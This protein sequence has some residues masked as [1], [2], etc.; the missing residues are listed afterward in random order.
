MQF[1]KSKKFQNVLYTT[2]LVGN[3]HCMK[4][5][6]DNLRVKH[7]W[8]QLC[9][10]I[11]NVQKLDHTLKETLGVRLGSS[12][13]IREFRSW[14]PKYHGHHG[15]RLQ[16]KAPQGIRLLSFKAP[17]SLAPNMTTVWRTLGSSS[18]HF[19]RTPDSLPR[20][21]QGHQGNYPQFQE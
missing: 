3:F 17:A 8:V 6:Q 19:S 18:P 4:I 5:T 9:W 7:R 2:V 11:K 21:N 14:T 13:D 15:V 20:K 16:F 12:K 1:K 10:S